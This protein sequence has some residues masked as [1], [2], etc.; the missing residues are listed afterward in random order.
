MSIRNYIYIE[1][2]DLAL[3]VSVKCGTNFCNKKKESE[4]ERPDRLFQNFKASKSW[5]RRICSSSELL[6]DRLLNCE[7]ACWVIEYNNFVASA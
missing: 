4:G 3:F 7:K 5:D 1:C 2:V 6:V